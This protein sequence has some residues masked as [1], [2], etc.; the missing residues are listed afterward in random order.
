[1]A[2][3][4]STFAN[5]GIRHDP[6]FITRV[7]DSEG[8]VI[9]RAPGGKRA[10]SPQVARTVTDVLS[11]VTEGTAPN[12]KLADDRLAGKTG[13]ATTPRTH[14]SPGTRRSWWRSCGWAT[15]RARS[16]R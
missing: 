7:E 15:R 4:Y 11:H 16:T 2:T 14:G 5:E 13:T 3:V 6:V 10:V 9:Y 8:R 12:A 1:M